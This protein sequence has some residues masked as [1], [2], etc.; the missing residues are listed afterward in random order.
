MNKEHRDRLPTHRRLQ[1]HHGDSKS[2]SRKPIKVDDALFGR[3][4]EYASSGM[5]R[6]IALAAALILVW[7]FI[8]R[9]QDQKCI[10]FPLVHQRTESIFVKAKAVP[11]NSSFSVIFF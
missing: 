4:L 1:A 5:S 11:T 6:Y 9:G 10:F 3:L 2:R 7:T 8:T